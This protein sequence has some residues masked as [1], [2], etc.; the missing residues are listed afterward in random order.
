MRVINMEKKL[1]FAC[2]WG[3]DKASAFSGTYIGIYK[4]L[5]KYYGVV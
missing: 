3:N 2:P 1:L 5:E 4:E